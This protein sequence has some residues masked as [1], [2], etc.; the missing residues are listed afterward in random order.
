[1]QD[2]EDLLFELLS[3]EAGK[4]SNNGRKP[5]VLLLTALGQ[6]QTIPSQNGL[7]VNMMVF[8]PK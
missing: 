2:R 1:M 4:Y 3:N 5:P 6:E 7:L 8:G